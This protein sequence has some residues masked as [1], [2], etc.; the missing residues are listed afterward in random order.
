MDETSGLLGELEHLA[1]CPSWC[2]SDSH[3]TTSPGPEHLTDL[4]DLDT[5]EG[6]VT[7]FGQDALELGHTVVLDAD[8]T[9]TLTQTRRLADELVALADL[10]EQP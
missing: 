5:V 4:R 6:R 9:M 8:A 10:V 3:S 2:A 7:T 1:N